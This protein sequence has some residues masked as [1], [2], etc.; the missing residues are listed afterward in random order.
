MCAFLCVFSSWQCV[1]PGRTVCGLTSEWWSTR[2]LK[3]IWCHREWPTRKWR[4]YHEI[5]WRQSTTE[6]HSSSLEFKSWFHFSDVSLIVSSSLH[7]WTM[8]KVFEELQ[9]SELKVKFKHLPECDLWISKL[10]AWTFT[11]KL[12]SVCRG[13]WRRQRSIIMLSRSL[14]SWEIWTVRPPY[15]TSL[16]K[17]GPIL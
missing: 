3:K 2:W 5:T 14:S 7:S 8:E 17:T 13:C 16:Q 4:R 6:T 12:L 9:A 11:N 10:N 15:F 1:N